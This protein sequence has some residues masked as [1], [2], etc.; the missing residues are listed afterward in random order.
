V[1]PARGRPERSA[2]PACQACAFSTTTV[3]AR[4]VTG[5]CLGWSASGS[6]SA[7]RGSRPRRCEPGTRRRAPLSGVEAS[8]SQTV[9]QTQ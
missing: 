9:L 1:P 6:T 2:V 7:C 5:S 8:G 4:P 3:P